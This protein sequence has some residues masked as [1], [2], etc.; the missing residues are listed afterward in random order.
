MEIWWLLTDL[1]SLHILDFF[2]LFRSLFIMYCRACR[3]ALVWRVGS[4][5][6]SVLDR[7]VLAARRNT[8]FGERVGSLLGGVLD[9]QCL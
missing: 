5:V 4:P 3:I 1:G 9:C 7:L 8:G 2:P 6:F